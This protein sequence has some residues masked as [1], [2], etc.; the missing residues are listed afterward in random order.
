MD[1]LVQLAASSPC[2]LWRPL[3]K[4]H[5]PKLAVDVLAQVSLDTVNAAGLQVVPVYT[6]EELWL[7]VLPLAYYLLQQQQHLGVSRLVVGVTGAGGSGKSVLGQFLTRVLNTIQGAGY[8]VCVGVDGYHRTN[9]WLEQHSLRPLKGRPETIDAE[10][11]A[12]DLKAVKTSPKEEHLLPA[13]DRKLHD[14]VFR[15]IAIPALPSAAIVVVEGILLLL[16]TPR[17]R[18]VGDLLDVSLYIQLP[19][20]VAKARINERKQA[21]GLSHEV[22]EAHYM[23]V[24][25]PNFFEMERSSGRANVILHGSHTSFAYPT[26]TVNTQCKAKL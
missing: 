11:L 13:Y 3:L 10:S 14:P 16:D 23:R 4:G 9:Q 20:V 7:C 17:F 22:A 26:V 21:G 24:D 1:S 8:S 15:A 25:H 2:S 5:V 12:S 19:E 18:A 6:I